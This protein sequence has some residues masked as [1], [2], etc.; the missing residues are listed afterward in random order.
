VLKSR[1]RHGPGDRGADVV[2]QCRGQARALGSRFTHSAPPGARLSTWRST[3]G[4][5]GSPTGEEFH[6]NGLTCIALRSV[7]C[8]AEPA[9]CGTAIDS[10]RDIGASRPPR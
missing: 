4:M 7:G 9:I 3:G 6:H 10:A 5:R 8:R 2:F 1:W